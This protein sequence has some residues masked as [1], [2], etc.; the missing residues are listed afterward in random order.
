MAFSVVSSQLQQVRTGMWGQ[1]LCSFSC[2]CSTGCER[3]EKAFAQLPVSDT[4]T[5]ASISR[6]LCSNRFLTPKF[7]F[8][9]YLPGH[10]LCCW[11]K[12]NQSGALQLLIS[13]IIS[14]EQD[15]TGRWG[16]QDTGAMFTSMKPLRGNEMLWK[17]DAASMTQVWNGVTNQINEFPGY[18]GRVLVMFGPL[19]N[20]NKK[21]SK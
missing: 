19:K 21:N 2:D 10:S 8:L 1:G 17:E 7:W 5:K 9:K 6:I 12:K 11:G 20:S 14:Q 3:K 15:L 13:L 4:D 18:G 16:G